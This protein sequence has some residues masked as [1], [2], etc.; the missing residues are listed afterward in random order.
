VDC[1]KNK[2]GTEQMG[3][4]IVGFFLAMNYG[5]EDSNCTVLKDSR[6]DIWPGRNWRPTWPSSRMVSRE[7]SNIDARAR[8][9]SRPSDLSSGAEQFYQVEYIWIYATIVYYCT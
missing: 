8:E 3:T 7:I 1:N 9:I 5:L 2:G 4:W 6:R